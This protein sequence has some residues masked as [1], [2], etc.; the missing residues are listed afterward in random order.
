MKLRVLRFR[1][2]ENRNVSVGVFPKRE[3]IL[4]GGLGL[5]GIALHG[6]SAGEAEMCEC[7]DGCVEN[8]S[9]MVE[10]FLEFDGSFAALMRDQ[11]GF[12]AHKNG[13]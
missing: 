2:D 1:S 8:N 10:N 4:I 12:A 6:V 9:T 13:K 3:E 5:G 11:I 7:A